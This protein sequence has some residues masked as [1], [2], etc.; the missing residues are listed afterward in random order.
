VVITTAIVSVCFILCI[1]FAV[2][3]SAHPFYVDSTPKPFQNIPKSP[4]E[5]SVFFSEP[6]E[7]P[8]SDISV[9]GP[10]G[11]IVNN[12]DSHNV[13][14]QTSSIASSLQDNLPPGTYTVNTKVLS[15]V[16]GHVVDNSFT[17]GMGTEITASIDGGQPQKDILSLEESLSRFPGYIGQVLA[18]GVSIAMIWLWKPFN[19]VPWLSKSLIPFRRLTSN[20]ATKIL[21]I[22]SSLILVSGV[23][24]IVIQ[25]SS[26]DATLF[27]IIST[28][29]GKVWTI[30][31]IQASALVLIAVGIYRRNARQGN[32]IK[33]TE[34]VAILALALSL[35]LTYS[36]IAH[37]AAINQTLA[38]LADFCH[39]IV[40]SVWIGGVIF[41]AFAC[42]PKLASFQSND[43]IKAIFFIY[44]HT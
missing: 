32:L 17:F 35:L 34:I 9:L 28:K 40:A 6:I 19:Q 7:L 11:K 8:Y 21:I 5:V 15:A 12:K 22:G 4:K 29:F 31:M 13:N 1:S 39:S 33:T 23:A 25:S 44:P 37:A 27:E 41:L 16:D 18:F 36:L 14:G 38:I 26:V 3:S 24:M 10:D 42:I 2:E 20:S 43:N 30:R